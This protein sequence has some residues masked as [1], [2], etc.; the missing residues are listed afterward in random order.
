MLTPIKLVD[1]PGVAVSALKI[2]TGPYSLWVFP[3]N[4]V[5]QV[6]YPLSRWMISYPKFKVVKP[7]IVPQ[8]ILMV[9]RLSRP[10]MATKLLFHYQDMLEHV[11]ALALSGMPRGRHPYVTL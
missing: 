11:P 2:E 5:H 6:L 3:Y 8:P 7:I 10:K 4:P 1:M 9:N